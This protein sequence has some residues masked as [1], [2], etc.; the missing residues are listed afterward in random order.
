MCQ[1]QIM[2]GMESS[3]DQSSLSN[4]SSCCTSHV[5]VGHCTALHCIWFVALH[6]ICSPMLL[7]CS[8]GVVHSNALKLGQSVR[9][10]GPDSGG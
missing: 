3:N 5:N 7:R 9:S 10:S 1:V 6:L 8:G 2:G 4:N